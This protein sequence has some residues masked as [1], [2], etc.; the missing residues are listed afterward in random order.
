[1][2]RAVVIKRAEL[3]LQP[4]DLPISPALGAPGFDA[5]DK[6]YLSLAVEFLS[7]GL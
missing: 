2:G 3:A 4:G 1:L 7:A 5:L 6:A